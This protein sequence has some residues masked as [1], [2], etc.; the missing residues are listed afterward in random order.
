MR[1]DRVSLVKDSLDLLRQ[2]RTGIANDSNHSLVVSLDA[3]MVRLELFL[4]SGGDDPR[5][6][7]AAL[8]VL[9]QGLAA[10]PGIQRIIE[11]ARDR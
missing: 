7:E 8:K 11:I 5:R 2:V 9:A 6:I 3:V 1:N 10:I 4:S